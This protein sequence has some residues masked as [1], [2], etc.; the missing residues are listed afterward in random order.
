MLVPTPQSQI[1]RTRGLR[2]QPTGEPVAQEQRGRGDLLNEAVLGCSIGSA[3]SDQA[4]SR[5]QTYVIG[6]VK[7]KREKTYP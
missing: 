5:M 7:S 6:R 2:A 1:R 4:L 3:R